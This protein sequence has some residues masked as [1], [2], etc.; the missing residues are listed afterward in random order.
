[1]KTKN[2]NLQEEAQNRFE[3]QLGELQ[4]KIQK[5]ND[6]FIS[7]RSKHSEME[8][9]YKEVTEKIVFVFDLYSK[10]KNGLVQSL[11]A[12]KS[13]A[14]PACLLLGSIFVLWIAI[15]MVHSILPAPSPVPDDHS[16]LTRPDLFGEE[17]NIVMVGNPGTGKSTLLNSLIGD[18]SIH[19]DSGLGLGTGVTTKHK[20]HKVGNVTYIDTPGLADVETRSSAAE[21]IRQA[22]MMNGN[23][24]LFFILTMRNGRIVNEDKTTMRMVLRA[25]PINHYGI[26]INQIKEKEQE[27]VN[28]P[29]NRMEI[30]TM[31]LSNLNPVTSRVYFQPQMKELIGNN[32][33]FQMPKSLQDFIHD[34]PCTMIPEGDV[35]A[36]DIQDWN[37]HSEELQ[38][39]Q[40]ELQNNKAARMQEAKE[41]EEKLSSYNAKLRQELDE[42]QKRNKE[43]ESRMR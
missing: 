7:L 13:F 41:F 39:L 3:A 25:A 2:T 33:Y 21:E 27:I 38:K 10:L 18:G 8:E 5:S 43:M 9:K 24:K 19:F 31:L 36:L 28:N 12:L 22:L 17:L 32:K 35:S 29:E 16:R 37:A 6:D 14:K 11:A 26:I 23:Y 4:I 34:T 42:A 40:S 1:L 20:G 30:Q 15:C